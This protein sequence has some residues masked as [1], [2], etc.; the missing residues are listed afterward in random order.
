MNNICL[1]NLSERTE[2]LYD[3]ISDRIRREEINFCTHCAEHGRYCGIAELTMEDKE[4]LIGIRDS[5]KDLQNMLH[6][7]QV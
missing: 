5:L 1:H 6:F 2:V 3:E 4:K 7:Y